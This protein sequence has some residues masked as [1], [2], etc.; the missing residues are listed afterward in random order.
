MLAKSDIPIELTHFQMLGEIVVKA[1]WPYYWR[2][3]YISIRA[4]PAKNDE[5]V[6]ITMKSIKGEKWL[7]GK[8]IEKDTSAYE[9][10]VNFCTCY[11]QIINDN[12][13]NLKFLTN[14]DPKL[15]VMPQWLLN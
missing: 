6:I 9:V 5:A 12:K 4:M 14:I 10:D 7:K 2:S 8:K 11:L 3:A 13:C 15:A 1:P